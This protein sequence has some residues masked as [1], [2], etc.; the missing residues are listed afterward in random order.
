MI[1]ERVAL[2]LDSMKRAAADAISFVA[3]MSEGEFL[4]SATTQ[5][6]CA[7]CLILIGEA[8][9]RIERRSPDF[10]AKHPDWPWNK[11]RGLRNRIVHDYDQLE[12]ST[13][14]VVIHESLPDLLSKIE[15]L[16]E[17]DPR[18]SSKD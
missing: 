15:A 11:I 1:D 7:M 8:T 6:A 13:I 2:S 4:E 3:E 12:M 18:L 16:G 9:A 10:V 5:K 17:L 14:W